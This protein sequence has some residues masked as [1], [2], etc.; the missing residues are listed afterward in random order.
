M[1]VLLQAM[2]ENISYEVFVS[3]HGNVRASPSL[4]ATRHR[5]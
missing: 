2:K 5:T 1:S 3:Q 4:R